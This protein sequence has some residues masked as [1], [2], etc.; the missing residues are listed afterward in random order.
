MHLYPIDRAVQRIA[1]ADTA[2]AYRGSRYAQVI[3]GVDPDPANAPDLERWARGYHDALHPHSAGGAYV[4]MLMHDEG[5]D[6][7]R[8][9]YRGNY[10]RLVEV[11]RRYDPGNFFHVNQN[12]TP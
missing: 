5:A 7:I 11:K 4:N 10:D 9:S 1:A 8:T 12:I 2:W 6:R 3:V